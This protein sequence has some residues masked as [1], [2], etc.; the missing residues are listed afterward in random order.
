VV[1]TK[2]NMKNSEVT[3]NVFLYSVRVSA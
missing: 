2:F 3:Q 1:A